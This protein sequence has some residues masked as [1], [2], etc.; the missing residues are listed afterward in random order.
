MPPDTRKIKKAQVLYGLKSWKGHLRKRPLIHL[1]KEI[2]KKKRS[3]MKL[4]LG[5][6]KT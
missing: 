4:A 1:F 2:E 6:Y 3:L 5:N